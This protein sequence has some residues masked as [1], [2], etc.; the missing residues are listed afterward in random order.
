MLEAAAQ[1]RLT[2]PLACQIYHQSFDAA[3]NADLGEV[4]YRDGIV[5]STYFSPD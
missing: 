3:W 1:P 4:C 2:P 5:V